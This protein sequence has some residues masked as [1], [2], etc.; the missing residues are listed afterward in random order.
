VFIPFEVVKAT[1]KAGDTWRGEICRNVFT[2]SGLVDKFTSWTPL[3]SRFLEPDNFA[4][5]AFSGETP[6][7]EQ[8]KQLTEELNLPYRRTVAAAIGAAAEIG[9]QYRGT[10]QEAQDDAV[11]G[12]RARALLREW[13][14]IERLSKQ[15]DTASILSLRQS[16]M[17]LQLLNQDSYE[18]KYRYLINKLLSEN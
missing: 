17:K 12:E 5:L 16:L 9:A 8:V 10:L 1:T 7:A 13:R 3:Q 15:G 11:L 2:S 6:S 4:T 18:L 14:Q